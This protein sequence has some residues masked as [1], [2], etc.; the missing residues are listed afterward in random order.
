MTLYLMSVHGTKGQEPPAPDLMAQTFADVDAF[1]HELQAKGHWVFAAGLHPID[2]ATTVRI[3]DGE[4][5]TVDGPYAETK[6]YLGGFWIVRAADLD[7][8]LAL[9]EQGARACQGPVEVRPI[10][11]GGDEAAMLAG[12]SA[13]QA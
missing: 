7:E 8:A 1:N 3:E 12:P 11:D 13:P 5:V 6:E 10:D 9:A 2:T 4:A